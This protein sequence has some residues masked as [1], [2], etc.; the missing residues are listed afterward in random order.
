MTDDVK[1]YKN[2][3]KL[4]LIADPLPPAM[5]LQ[6]GGVQAFSVHGQDTIFSIDRMGHFE[7]PS[8]LIEQYGDTYTVFFSDEGKYFVG[9]FDRFTTR[10]T[11]FDM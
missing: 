11:F 9:F 5:E 7:V 6:R 10:A 2:I 1:S 8:N 4:A 3:Y